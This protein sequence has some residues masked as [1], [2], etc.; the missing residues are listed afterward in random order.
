MD[1][2]DSRAQL[3]V[4]IV[5][6]A[7]RRKASTLVGGNNWAVNSWKISKALVQISL[8]WI[9]LANLKALELTLAL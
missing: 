3:N 9:I 4:K 5:L 8:G 1:L 6:Q 2:S 7:G